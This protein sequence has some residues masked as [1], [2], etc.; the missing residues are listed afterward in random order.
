MGLL[1]LEEGEVISPGDGGSRGPDLICPLCF[2]LEVMGCEL[3]GAR[4]VP[5]QFIIGLAPNTGLREY[6]RVKDR[7]Q[8]E[9]W[10]FKFPRQSLPIV[11]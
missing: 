10:V 6:C 3:P 11:P 7:T 9:T 2:Y 8:V 4:S 1:S 5:V